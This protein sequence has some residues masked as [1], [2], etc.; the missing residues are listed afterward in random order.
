MKIL[1]QRNK[2]VFFVFVFLQGN[3][4]QF[5]TFNIIAIGNI[6]LDV[7]MPHKI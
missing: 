1:Q 5:K 7:L 6:W 4:L 3:K 2:K